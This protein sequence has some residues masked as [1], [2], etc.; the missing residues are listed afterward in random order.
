LGLQT[1]AQVA[2]WA[3]ERERGLRRIPA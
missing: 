2:V 1:R 3:L